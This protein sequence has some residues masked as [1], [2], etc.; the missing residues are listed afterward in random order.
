VFGTGPNNCFGLLSL[1]SP[2]RT[3]F[4]SGVA[5]Q[6]IPVQWLPV[7]EYVQ[8]GRTLGLLTIR[9]QQVNSRGSSCCT[10]TA[11]CRNREFVVERNI[12]AMPMEIGRSASATGYWS[13]P[14]TTHVI[15]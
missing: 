11:Q 1:R 10:L 14:D 12:D 2:A 7:F 6:K 9:S 4:V 13:N 3:L 15:A 5:E 8:V